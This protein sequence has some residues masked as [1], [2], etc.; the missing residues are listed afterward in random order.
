MTRRPEPGY[1]ASGSA[2]TKAATA[3]I[4]SSVSAPANA[5]MTL[6][7]E[8]TRTCAA[9]RSSEARALNSAAVRSRTPS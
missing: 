1:S 4:W 3:A 9:T 8:P 2:S 6:L 5:G 7:A